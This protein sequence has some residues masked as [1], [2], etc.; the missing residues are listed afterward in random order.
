MP[1]AA[2]LPVF[3]A[4]VLTA[5][6][7]GQATAERRALA[8]YDFCGF[9]TGPAHGSYEPSGGGDS[10]MVSGRSHGIHHHTF[11]SSSPVTLKVHDSVIM[12]TMRP[13]DVVLKRVDQ[14]LSF[15]IPKIRYELLIEGHYCR[16]RALS[17]VDVPNNEIEEFRFV[18]AGEIWLSDLLFAEWQKNP[19]GLPERN[20]EW[21][22]PG[23]WRVRPFSAVMPDYDKPAPGCPLF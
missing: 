3:A 12:E 21:V 10:L 4:I 17:D 1:I 7:T 13:E 18:S 22:P 15:C 23:P 14:H 6:G 20:G 19:A 11:D 5:L 16:A 8:K 9:G 2:T